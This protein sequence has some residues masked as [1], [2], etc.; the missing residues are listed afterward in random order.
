VTVVLAGV[1]ET[2]AFG[3]GLVGLKG[4]MFR[5]FA[6]AAARGDHHLKAIEGDDTPRSFEAAMREGQVVR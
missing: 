3:S 5:L 1:E 4:K 6:A 2:R